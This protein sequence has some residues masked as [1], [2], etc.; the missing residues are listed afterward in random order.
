M[1]KAIL[2]TEIQSTTEPGNYTYEAV[3]LPFSV[4]E[5]ILVKKKSKNLVIFV[6]KKKMKPGLVL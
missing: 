1:Y 2:S 3:L 4:D 5:A 6:F